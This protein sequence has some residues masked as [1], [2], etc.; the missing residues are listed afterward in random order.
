MSTVFKAFLAPTLASMLVFCTAA[1]LPF[2]KNSPDGL[3]EDFASHVPARTAVLPCQTWRNIKISAED[4]KILCDKF[5]E[6]VMDG[7]RAQPYMRGFSPKVV[8]KLLDQA[9][10]PTAISEG[11][12][13]ILGSTKKMACSTNEKPM[14]ASV[15]GLYAATLENSAAW[16]MWLAKFSD[17]QKHADA[18][19]VPI[20][21]SATDKRGDDRGLIALSRSVNFSLWL[22]DTSTGKLIWTRSKAGTETLRALP[23]RSANLRAPEWA[24]PLKRALT[25]DFWRDYPGRLVLD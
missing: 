21:V 13:V 10:W 9:K 19:L 23:E 6:A 24:E 22:I 25:Q 1:C 17:A 12:E 7:F 20:L 16:Q 8:D 15:A 2:Y 11:F 18:I 5:D 14:C 4:R 3:Q